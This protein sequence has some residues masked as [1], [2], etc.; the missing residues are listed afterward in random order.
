MTEVPPCLS[1]QGAM[2]RRTGPEPVT[3]CLA[4]CSV[5]PQTAA[6]GRPSRAA[7]C[8]AAVVADGAGA[9]AS[10]GGVAP[11]VCPEGAAC[12][13]GGDGG[14]PAGVATGALGCVCEVFAGCWAGVV[15]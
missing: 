8:A 9:P 5:P 14:A 10:G 11:G 1:K 4:G 15:V 7:G 6:A 12:G 3:G 2:A 13:S